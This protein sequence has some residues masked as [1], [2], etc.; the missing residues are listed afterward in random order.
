MNSP[1]TQSP[2]A[3]KTFRTVFARMVGDGQH[4]LPA[5]ERLLAERVARELAVTA[6]LVVAAEADQL[7]AVVDQPGPCD[8]GN[9]IG[10][11]E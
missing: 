11:G 3:G 10:G 6:A 7:V 5:P 9:R 8:I 1:V 4:V 2:G